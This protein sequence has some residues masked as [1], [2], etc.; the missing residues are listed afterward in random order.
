MQIPTNIDGKLRELMRVFLAENANINL[1][2]LRTEETCWVGNIQDSLACL[3][4]PELYSLLTTHYSL[5]SFTASTNAL[6]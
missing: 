6:A 5:Y 4:I 2:A 1:S 3:D